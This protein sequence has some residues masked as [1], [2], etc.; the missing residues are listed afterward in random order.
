M[1]MLDFCILPVKD[2]MKNAA[3]DM[4]VFCMLMFVVLMGT[5]PQAEVLGPERLC[6]T[7]R[8]GRALCSGCPGSHFHQQPMTLPASFK[9][10]M[11]LLVCMRVCVC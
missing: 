9:N 4:H 7:L 3:I 8:A 10:Y 2:I 6:L 11:Y 1:A 5:D